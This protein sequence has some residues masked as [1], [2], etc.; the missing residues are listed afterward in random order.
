MAKDDLFTDDAAEAAPLRSAAVKG[1]ARSRSKG[2]PEDSYNASSIEVLEGLEPVRR[3]PGMYVGGTDENAMHHLFAEVID[4]AMDEAVA[5]HATFIE[6]EV[7]A[8]GSASVNDN[9]RGMPVDRHPKFKD[10]SALEVIMSMLHSGGKFGSDAYETSGGLHGVGVS[11]VNALS[12]FVE[13]EVVRNK[14][15]Y[16]QRYARGHALGP[17]EEVGEVRN[18]RGTKVTFR[19]D[20]QIFGA[21]AH[22][23]PERLFAASRSK[24]YLFSGVEIRWKCAP[25]LAAAAKVPEAATFHFPGGLKE[26]L[27]AEIDGS[28]TVTAIF[29]GKTK[30]TGHGSAEWAV[31]WHDGDGF[32]RSYCN[33]IPTRDGG[34][35]EAGLRAALL[36]GLKGHAVRVGKKQAQ[37]ITAEDIAGSCAAMLSVFIREPEFVGQTKDRLASTEATRVVVIEI[38][39]P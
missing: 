11:V 4:N 21:G 39:D 19:P 24:A 5:G 18:R 14:R 31:A 27:A 15:L 34:T 36:R 37:I 12:E 35:H 26:Y 13:V 22:L 32:I 38:R 1:T 10:K 9:G 23:R 30:N 2:D 16:R 7:D 6:V 33:T 3:R 17:L 28:E 8:D 25:E 29:A 20:P